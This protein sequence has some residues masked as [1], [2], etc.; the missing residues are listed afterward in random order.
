MSENPPCA[1]RC[2]LVADIISRLAIANGITERY[3]RVSWGLTPDFVP[4]VP[5]R[6]TS[7]SV[8][9]WLDEHED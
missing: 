8:A 9:R 2:T 4:P 7:S 3:E 6:T 1:D 5:P